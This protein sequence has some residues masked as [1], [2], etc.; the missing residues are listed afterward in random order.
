MPQDPASAVSQWVGNPGYLVLSW[1]GGVGVCNIS[2]SFTPAYVRCPQ[3]E[4]APLQ[5]INL[6]VNGTLHVFEIAT[7]ETLTL[8]TIWHDL[9]FF[10]GTTDPRG[11][12]TQGLKSLLSFVRY[13]LSYYANSCTIMTPD[14]MIENV[15]YWG[16]LESFQ[17]ASDGQNISPRAGRWAGSISFL[18]C[19]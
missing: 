13:T 15:Q 3:F 12:Y 16:G 9:P 7:N 4:Y 6:S 14:G 1:A 17:E 5:R 18:R 2:V 19:Q 8:P 11:N 10:D